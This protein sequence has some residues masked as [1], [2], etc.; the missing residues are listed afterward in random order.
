MLNRQ[1]TILIIVAMMIAIPGAYYAA[2][3]WLSG[4]AYRTDI[5]PLILISGGIIALVIT[6]LTVAFHSIKASRTNPAETLK[7]E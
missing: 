5:N 4:F 1:F 6:Y 7:C 3:W 2:E